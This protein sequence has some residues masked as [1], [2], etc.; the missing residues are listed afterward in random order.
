MDAVALRSK[1]GAGLQA[2]Q[3]QQWAKLQSWRRHFVQTGEQQA[4]ADAM[5]VSVRHVCQ[6]RQGPL[7]GALLQ[8]VRHDDGKL[9]EDLRGGFHAVGDIPPSGTWAPRAEAEPTPLAPSL[10]SARRRQDEGRVNLA[11]GHRAELWSAA[12]E[13]VAKGV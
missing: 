1:L 8:A 5:P 10:G 13:Q 11:T 12:Q 7:P 9:L 4:R 2:F 6:H 3:K